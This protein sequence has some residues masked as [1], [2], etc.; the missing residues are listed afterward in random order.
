MFSSAKAATHRDS[1]KDQEQRSLVI[2][3]S[4]SLVSHKHLNDLMPFFWQNNIKPVIFITPSNTS[5]RSRIPSLQN[6]EFYDA[7]IASDVIYPALEKRNLRVA[8]LSLTFNQLM[9]RYGANAHTVTSLKDPAI[10]EAVNQ[11]GFIGAVSIYQDAI[12]KPDLIDAIKERGFLWNLHPALLPHD[13][14]MYVMFW[15]LMNGKTEHG[16]TLH[17]IDAGIDTGRLISTS[18][19]PLDKSKSIVESYIDFAAH[20]SNLLK[21]ALARHLRGEAVQTYEQ[22][23]EKTN[24]YSYPTEEDIAR[25]WE[26]GV[27]LWGTPR[28]M[29]DMYGRIFGEDRTMR[30]QILK[31]IFR[32]EAQNAPQEERAAETFALPRRRE[33][34]YAMAKVNADQGI[35]LGR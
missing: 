5:P 7:D 23:A 28:E 29:A 11:P 14:G 31:S 1:S 3:T 8:H 16:Y 4:D 33:A 27:R 12:F 18:A 15:S 25:G 13:K 21:D 24:Y 10:M 26:Q 35:R 6:F 2:F 34:H 19:G 32:R 20:G 22:V 17:E 30:Q 9:A